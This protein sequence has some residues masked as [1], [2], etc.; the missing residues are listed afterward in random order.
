MTT[1]T[2]TQGTHHEWHHHYVD[3]DDVRVGVISYAWDRDH[4]L[5]EMTSV[6]WT[7][8][9]HLSER[10]SRGK[11]CKRFDDALQ[12]IKDGHLL[13]G[14]VRHTEP[15]FLPHDLQ[16]YF[17]E[18]DLRALWFHKDSG[19]YFEEYYPEHSYGEKSYGCMVLNDD[20]VFSEPLAALKWLYKKTDGLT[21]L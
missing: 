20:E 18:H 12:F 3:V 15:A 14:F 17:V 11:I 21:Q 19:F 10:Y 8:D 9:Y 4:Y 5:A 6:S 16:C 2:V 1:F 7:T 13:N